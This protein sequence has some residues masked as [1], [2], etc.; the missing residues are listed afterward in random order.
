MVSFIF[1]HLFGVLI[2]TN[3]NTLC[4]RRMSFRLSQEPALHNIQ[5]SCS[6]TKKTGSGCFLNP[7]G[8]AKFCGKGGFISGRLFGFQP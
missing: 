3:K 6:K 7:F 2:H 5:R 4:H 1:E 8:T